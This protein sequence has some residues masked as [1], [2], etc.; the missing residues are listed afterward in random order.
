MLI[1]IIFT[2]LVLVLVDQCISRDTDVL[3]SIE[4]AAH[5]NNSNSYGAAGAFIWIC[6]YQYILYDIFM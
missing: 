6:E 2:H 4:T 1:V 3:E 5:N